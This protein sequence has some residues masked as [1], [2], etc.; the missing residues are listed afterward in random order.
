MTVDVTWTLNGL[1][2]IHQVLSVTCGTTTTTHPTT[3]TT[4]VTTTT[5]HNT[6]TTAHVTTTTQ[7]QNG[8]N[9]DI[10]QVELRRCT[11]VHTGY[12]HFPA[13][14]VIHWQ[15]KQSG[16]PHR[17]G[18][19]TTV[20][21]NGYHFITQLIGITLRP[22]PVKGQIL[23]SW[24]ARGTMQHYSVSREPGCS[25]APPGGTSGGSSGGAGT[26]REVDLRQCT[27][28]H[29]GYANFPVHTTVSWGVKQGNLSAAAPFKAIGF[30]ETAKGSG[31]HFLMSQLNAKLGHAANALV[32]FYWAVNGR[33][34]SYSATRKP[35][36]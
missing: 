14:T 21:G 19:F 8:G 29:L 18:S 24:L 3:T 7:P 36:C 6:T 33:H 30:F 32:T 31:S 28:L 4:H 23:Y 17:S 26:I 11:Q 20:A 25:S 22:A 34:M 1:N 9:G 5:R 35:G 15:V 27:L 16:R 10:F 12:Q 2:H 13:G